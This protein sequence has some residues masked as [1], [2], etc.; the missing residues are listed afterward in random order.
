MP[1]SPHV[2]EQRASKHRFFEYGRQNASD[3]VERQHVP[4]IAL[5]HLNDRVRWSNIGEL[6]QDKGDEQPY[7]D[8]DQPC[9]VTCNASCNLPVPSLSAMPAKCLP[10]IVAGSTSLSCPE[11]CDG[12]QRKSQPIPVQIR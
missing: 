5:E 10:A 8:K 1:T 6:H 2:M 4:A 7:G 3:S 11:H 9:Q 12:D